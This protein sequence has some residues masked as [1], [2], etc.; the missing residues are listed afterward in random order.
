MPKMNLDQ[1]YNNFWN[2]SKH[3]GKPSSPR[4][5][6]V[7]QYYDNQKKTLSNRGP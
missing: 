2:D 6:V 5:I 1:A 3:F 7:L 4:R